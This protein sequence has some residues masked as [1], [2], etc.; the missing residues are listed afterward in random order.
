MRESCGP[1]TT[2]YKCLVSST[3]CVSGRDMLA[4][5]S[6]ERDLLWGTL[7]VPRPNWGL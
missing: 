2:N 4:M 5:E 1:A 3:Y 7:P 6:L